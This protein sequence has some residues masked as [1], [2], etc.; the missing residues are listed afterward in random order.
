MVAYID[1][2]TMSL[3]RTDAKLSFLK[4]CQASLMHGWRKGSSVKKTRRVCTCLYLSSSTL[5][6]TGSCLHKSCIAKHLVSVWVSA[7]L[8]DA[9]DKQCR[10]IPAGNTHT[11]QPTNT[12]ACKDC[13]NAGSTGGTCTACA[14][15]CLACDDANTCT[16]GA[17]A[18]P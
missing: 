12:A 7:K 3:V 15:N 18:M 14:A 4:Q 1:V 11:A 2:Q 6:T 17:C 5:K 8:I 9:G 13:A 16:G 10:S